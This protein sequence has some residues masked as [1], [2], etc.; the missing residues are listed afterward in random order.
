MQQVELGGGEVNLFVTEE[1]FVG[2]HVQGEGIN[3]QYGVVLFL[4]AAATAQNGTDAG[5]HL[6]EGEGLG[7][8]VVT[9]GTQTGHLVFGGV[10]C[11][12]EQHGGGG[13]VFAQAAGHLEAVHAGHHDVQ[14]DEVGIF[15]VCLFEGFAAVAGGNYFKT[16]E[17]QGGG[18]QFKN[19]E[20]VIDD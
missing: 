14:D 15:G 18:E 12:Q 10:L 20:L 11:G 19:V 5:D 2:V 7:D 6:V 16:G 3:A 17:T 8:V 4:D 9:T 1:H 13:A